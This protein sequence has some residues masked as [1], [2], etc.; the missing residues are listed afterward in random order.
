ASS[1]DLQDLYEQVINLPE[2]TKF[3]NFIF[4]Q[5]ADIAQLTSKEF[6]T[7]KW[8]A[9][10]AITALNNQSTNKVT[11][12][13]M[14]VWKQS[15]Q[16]NKA[17]SNVS[18]QSA[19]VNKSLASASVQSQ[20]VNKTISSSSVQ[21]QAVDATS[22]ENGPAI[23]SSWAESNN[24]LEIYAT[25]KWHSFENFKVYSG[26]FGIENDTALL[27]SPEFSLLNSTT[28][29]PLE[30]HASEWFSPNIVGAQGWGILNI[31]SKKEF[32]H[33]SYYDCKVSIITPG[34]SGPQL[35]D[36]ERTE[37]PR[38]CQRLNN[39]RNWNYEKIKSLYIR[40]S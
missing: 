22:P 11:A 27:L 19:Q 32:N 1:D 18:I 33:C 4:E 31:A 20:Q 23:T 35:S 36:I 3:A 38:V 34:Y 8:A 37:S 9:A 25:D 39:L 16:V 5:Q 24:T 2:V 10:D 12:T 28:A 26:N 6:I 15:E 30:K 40:I 7:L 13:K 17:V 21:V 14:G 29:E